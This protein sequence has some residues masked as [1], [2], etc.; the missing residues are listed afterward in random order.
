MAIS[1]LLPLFYDPA[2]SEAMIHHSMD[3][4]KRAV[5][6]LN[7]DQVPVITLDQPLYAISKRIQWTWPMTHGED[8]FIVLFG[9]LHIE[10]AALK[11]LGDLLDSSGWTEALVQAGVASPGMAPS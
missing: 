4:V 10:M 3:V 11:V 7:P 2:H 9:G 5:H 6:I 1:S 8:H